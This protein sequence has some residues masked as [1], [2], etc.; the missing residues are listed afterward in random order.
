MLRIINVCLVI[1]LVVLAY[2]IYQVKYE[3]RGLDHAIASV[4]K[5]IDAERDAVA[6]LRAEWS[7]LNRPD[8]IERLAK[9]YIH[10]EASAPRQIVTLERLTDRDFDR[11]RKDEAP[12][13]AKPKPRPSQPQVASKSEEVLPWAKSASLPWHTATIPSPIRASAE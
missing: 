11:G 8:R 4:G 5:D 1:G 7:L 12:A 6:V 2:F 10:L 3:A 13:N 9:K